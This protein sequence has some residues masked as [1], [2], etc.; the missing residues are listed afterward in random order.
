MTSMRRPEYVFRARITKASRSRT[1]PPTQMHIFFR[2]AFLGAGLSE[3]VIILTQPA[4]EL[5]QF[6]LVKPGTLLMHESMLRVEK[7]SQAVGRSQRQ[8]LDVI[9]FQIDHMEYSPRQST[10][11]PSLWFVVRA[12]CQTVSNKVRLP[13]DSDLPDFQSLVNIRCSIPSLCG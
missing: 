7:G 8:D 11:H 9:V 1:P 6:G 5:I 13:D 4:P 2:C 10:Y 12:L 3:D